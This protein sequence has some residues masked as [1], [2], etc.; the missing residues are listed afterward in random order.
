VRGP[1]GE[2]FCFDLL[3]ENVTERKELEA[4]LAQAENMQAIGQLAGGIAH[5]FNRLLT[6]INGYCDL[7][8]YDGETGSRRRNV[9]TIHRAGNGRRALRNRPCRGIRPRDR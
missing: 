4:R 3:A 5:D 2:T 7:M 6:V 8:L 9:Q 1:A